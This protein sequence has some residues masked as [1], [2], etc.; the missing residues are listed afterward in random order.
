MFNNMFFLARQIEGQ[1]GFIVRPIANIFGFVVNLLFEFVY[2]IG[3]SHSL[4]FTIILMTII[5]RACMMPLSIRAQKSMARMRE[6]KPE[7]DKIDAKYGKSKDPEIMKKANQEKQILM[8]K[9][10]ANP[11]KG[12]FPML[13][14]MPLFIGLNFIM[15][16]AFLYINRLNDIYYELAVA[17]QNVPDF[18]IILHDIVVE[19]LP[20]NMYNNFRDALPRY[21][22]GESIAYLKDTIGDFLYAHDPADL[23]RAISR[24]T[25]EHWA[26]LQQNIPDAY[27]TSIDSINQTRTTI[28]TFFGL[29]MTEASSLSWPQVILPLL[30][31]LTMICSSWLMQQRTADPNA[32]DQQKLQQKIMLF[33]MP[34]FMV[35]ITFG[36]P[37]GV[38]LFWVTS[39]VFQVCQ[40]LILN[41]KD[42]IPLNL[43]FLKKEKTE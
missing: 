42:G 24:F 28:E 9:H 20:N 41:R 30:T 2:M 37:A 12:C 25:S 36:L 15:R 18:E 23:S 27:W 29:S 5:F 31:G 33:V 19:L 22:A 1:P 38:A 35:F 32:N 34:V 11:L 8:Q 7:L 13:L 26:Y 43:P 16:Q 14:Q 40:D 39:Q 10:D 4:G 21:Q 6:L 17:I 3:A